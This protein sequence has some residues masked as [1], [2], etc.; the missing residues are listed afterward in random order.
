M[1]KSLALVLLNDGLNTLNIISVL[2]VSRTAF[3]FVAVRGYLRV[4][5]FLWARVPLAVKVRLPSLIEARSGKQQELAVIG[6]PRRARF[7][8]G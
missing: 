7:D 1:G 3:L 5:V 2:R 4:I 6:R 8:R